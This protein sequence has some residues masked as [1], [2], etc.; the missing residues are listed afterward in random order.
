[1]SDEICLRNP[2]LD[3]VQEQ[4]LNIAHITCLHYGQRVLRPNGVANLPL[5][6]PPVQS[7]LSYR[8]AVAD[9]NWSRGH[10]QQ[11]T[12]VYVELFSRYETWPS[13][14]PQRGAHILWTEYVI[15]TQN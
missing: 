12:P 9:R 7:I 5:V 8:H 6:T 15:I 3:K 4:R 13:S 2:L 10:H 1:M 14:A 11:A